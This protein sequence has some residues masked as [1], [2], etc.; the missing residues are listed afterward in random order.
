MQ[1][2][3][4]LL[5]RFPVAK[6]TSTRIVHWSKRDYTSI[7]VFLDGAARYQATT[8]HDPERIRFDLQDTSIAAGLLGKKPKK[9]EMVWYVNDGLVARIHAAQEVP[10]PDVS[11]RHGGP[12]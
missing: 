11:R 9:E 1:N 8:L 6:R 10:S 3:S 2:R 12:I 5:R 4:R 7:A